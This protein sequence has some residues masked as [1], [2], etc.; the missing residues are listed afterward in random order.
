MS[1]HCRRPFIIQAIPPFSEPPVAPSSG[2]I[3]KRLS[4]GARQSTIKPLCP[5]MNRTSSDI[6][7]ERCRAVSRIVLCC[8]TSRSASG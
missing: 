2:Q 4:L 3:R 1:H 7:P 5:P 8:G 6:P